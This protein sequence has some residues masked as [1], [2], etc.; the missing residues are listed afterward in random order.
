MFISTHSAHNKSSSHRFRLAN[1][2]QQ[3]MMPNSRPTQVW[4]IVTNP[5]IERL[6]KIYP[7]QKLIKGLFYFYWLVSEFRIITLHQ[8]TYELM[9]NWLWW[10]NWGVPR[11]FFN[12]CSEGKEAMGALIP[13]IPS[14]LTTMW[15]ARVYSQFLTTIQKA[16]GGWG[17]RIPALQCCSTHYKVHSTWMLQLVLVLGCLRT[18]TNQSVP[19]LQ[20]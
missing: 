12:W 5:Y 17:L 16:I 19:V 8:I 2:Q 13:P 14:P 18:N 10:H 7:N 11:L 1:M 3:N 20:C 4:W 9:P 15:W 6:L